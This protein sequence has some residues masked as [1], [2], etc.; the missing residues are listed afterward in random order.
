MESLGSTRFQ[1]GTYF[2]VNLHEAAQFLRGYHCCEFFNRKMTQNESSMSVNFFR[3]IFLR[4]KQRPPFCQGAPLVSELSAE[5][6]IWGSSLHLPLLSRQSFSKVS[7]FIFISKTVHFHCLVKC[8]ISSYL[9]Y[10]TASGWSFCLWSLISLINSEG[11]CQMSLP[12]TG[13]YVMPFR[14]P[15]LFHVAMPFKSQFLVLIFRAYPPYLAKLF[16]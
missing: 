14:S 6:E 2:K 7:P 13:L 3:F 12:K 4:R 16:P 1:W 8:L 9:H 15:E 10:A 5:F 11:C